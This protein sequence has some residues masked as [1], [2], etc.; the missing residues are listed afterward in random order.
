MHISGDDQMTKMDH[1][2]SVYIGGKQIHFQKSIS[3][4]KN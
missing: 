4:D 1:Y 3:G 2:L